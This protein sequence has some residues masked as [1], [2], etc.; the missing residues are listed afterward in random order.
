MDYKDQL[1]DKRWKEKRL[2]ILRRD[3]HTC[4]IC[5]YFGSRVNVHHKKYTG[6]AWD[7]PDEDL[8]TLCKRCHKKTHKP[9]LND[10]RFDNMRIGNIIRNNHG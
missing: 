3:K 4:Q 2:K 8:I 6:Y 9:E 10:K 1:N 5:G 7:A